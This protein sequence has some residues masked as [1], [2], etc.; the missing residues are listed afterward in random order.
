MPE[1]VEPE[2]EPV[3][4]GPSGDFAVESEATLTPGQTPEGLVRLV[5][6]QGQVTFVEPA[7]VEAVV[8]DGDLWQVETDGEAAA[9]HMREGEAAEYGSTAETVRAFGEG[10]LRGL[11]FGLSDLALGD[12]EAEARRRINPIAAGA[13]Q[14]IGELAPALVTGG[15]SSMARLAQL[16]PAGRVAAMTARMAEGAPASLIGRIGRGAAAGVIDG[17][18]A[19][20]GQVISEAALREDV[21]FSAEALASGLA[22]G[23]ALGGVAGGTLAGLLRP[24]ERGLERLL[25][26]GTPEAAAVAARKAPRA[27]SVYRKIRKARAVADDEVLPLEQVVGGQL[28]RDAPD[29]LG[30]LAAIVDD[31]ATSSRPAELMARFDDPRVAAALPGADLD[32]VRG[33]AQKLVSEYSEAAADA[34]RWAGEY[35]EAFG[36]TDVAALTPAQ[37]ARQVPDE[38]EERGAVALARLDEARAK[39][40]AVVDDLDAAV[41]DPARA[42]MA[43]AA[44]PGG[45]MFERA[46][47]AAGAVEIA[48]QVGIGEGLPGL[49][50]IPVIGDALAMYLKFKAGAAALAGRGFLPATSATRAAAGVNQLRTELTRRVGRAATRAV[51]SPITSRAIS[52]VARQIR[53]TPSPEQAAEQARMENQGLPVDVQEGAAEV[54]GRVAGYLRATAPPNLLEGTPSAGKWR[55]SDQ[56]ARDYA[57]RRQAAQEPLKAIDNALAGPFSMLEAEALQACYPAIYAQV[58]RELEAQRD[59]LAKRLPPGRLRQISLAFGVTLSVDTAEG[60]APAPPSLPPFQPAPEFGAP[61]A[62]T[63]SPMVQGATSER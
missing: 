38:L 60:Y 6:S 30:K 45:G 48:G 7:A 29:S 41:P 37:L 53:E 14:L 3:D 40:D 43:T 63:T 25:A 31:A 21:D 44:G 12:A 49:R 10:G 35:A 17:A 26:E 62:S 4:A 32:V 2:F 58:Q 54:A 5:S 24:A 20:A 51:G 18:A 47:Q 39:L 11:T 33:N 9:R 59:K 28:R 8:G 34:K 42:A 55:P 15:Q 57:R 16:S 13:G 50:N 36:A 52:K 22:R 61:S 27:A 46:Q 19:G 1:R 23:A 56:E